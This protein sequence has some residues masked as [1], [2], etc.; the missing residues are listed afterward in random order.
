M[1]RRMCSFELPGGPDSSTIP[2]SGTPPFKS[3]SIGGQRVL[4]VLGFCLLIDPIRAAADRVEGKILRLSPLPSLCEEE[5]I[6]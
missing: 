6:V 3:V 1:L 4:N 2:P 5:Y